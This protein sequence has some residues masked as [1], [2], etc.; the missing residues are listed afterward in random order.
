MTRRKRGFKVLG[1]GF[2][3]VLSVMTLGITSAQAAEFLI[4]QEGVAKT[5]KELG[6]TAESVTGE[7]E[8]PGYL[9]VNGLGF[10]LQ[11]ASA[12][13][14]EG[15]LKPL[16]VI[17]GKLLHLNCTVL[18]SG[19]LLHELPC[20]VQDVGGDNELGKILINKMHGGLFSHGGELYVLVKP[21]Q[22]ELFLSIQLEGAECPLSGTYA[23]TGQ[24]IFLIGQ[25]H[26]QAVLPLT[27][28][29]PSLFVEKLKFGERN[30]TLVG[31]GV[32]RLN[33]A[34]AGEKWGAH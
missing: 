20:Q 17:T 30:A 22:G 27:V 29:N 3:A 1:L 34:F 25:D 24:L 16:G 9:V 13:V 28:S 4:L 5:F 14:L 2:L 18:E 7:M 12:H 21:F 6:I 23:V 32:A 19:A 8:E 31:S 26:A 11:C 33:G 15:V 10:E